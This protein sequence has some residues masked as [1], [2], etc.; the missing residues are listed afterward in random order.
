MTR[1]WRAAII[2]THNRPDDLVRVAHA[3]GPQVDWLTI[4]ANAA[5]EGA[6]PTI[7]GLSIPYSVIKV[8]DQPPNLALNMNRG[9]TSASVM[10]PWNTV[11]WD[12]AVLCDDAPPPPG[13]FDAVAAGLDQTNARVGCTHHRHPDIP[14]RFMDRPDKD[15]WMR[16]T[17]WAF[18]VRED[19]REAPL[20]LDEELHWW[21]QDTDLDWT[22]RL[23]GGV[24]IAPG[25]VVPN[26]HPN[27]YTGSRPDCADRIHFDGLHFD[28]KWAE[29]GGR[30]W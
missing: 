2:L 20:R 28:Q 27:D 8:D 11:L 7:T 13:W 26:L 12:M 1:P 30:P 21:W 15:I 22:A 17:G 23:N 9:L 4:V 6:I 29:Y 18:V 24:V 10:R 3:V 19:V 5:P 14:M 16:L 25:P